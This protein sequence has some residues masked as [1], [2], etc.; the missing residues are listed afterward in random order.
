MKE[1]QERHSE[2]LDAI[3][4]HLRADRHREAVEVINE[5]PNEEVRDFTFF[6]CMNVERG[7]DWLRNEVKERVA[8]ELKMANPHQNN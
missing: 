3:V 8:A 5:I 2:R 4:E 6:V 1:S 7:L